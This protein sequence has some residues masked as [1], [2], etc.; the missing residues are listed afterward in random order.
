[1]ETNEMKAVNALRILSVDMIQKA[2]SG[3]PGV[4]IDAAPM[5]FA[6][7]EKVMHFNPNYA[8]WINRDRFVLSA[9]HGS[10]LLYSLL[11]FNGFGLTI[12]D[13]KNFRQLGSKTP[14]HPEVGHTAGV[15]ATTGPLSQGIATAVGMALAEKHLA[16]IYNKPGFPVIDHYTYSLIGD[17]DLMEGL[18]EEALNIAGDK[19]LSKLIVLYDSNDVSLDGPLSLSTD[20]DVKAR[21]EAAGWDYRLVVDGNTD[22]DAI[23]AAIRAAQH[24]NRPSLIE[25]KTTIGYGAPKQGTNAVHGAALGEDGVRKLREFFDW[26]QEPFEFDDE[27]TDAFTKAVED[28][29]VIYDQW[30]KMFAKYSATYPSEAAQLTNSQL[31]M[32]AVTNDYQIGDEIATRVASQNIMNQI[33]KTNP[34]FWGGAADLASSNKTLLKDQGVFTPDDPAGNNIFF[35]VREFGMATAINGI[36]L[37]GGSRAFGS[38]FFVFS[39]Y[40]RAAVR[41]AAIMNLPS[42]FIGSHDSIAVGEDGPTHEPIEQLTSF[43][44]MPNLNLIRPADANETL[45]AWKLIAQTTDRPS[46]LVTSR[47]KLPVLAQT[48]DAPIEKG[49][50]IV[51]DAKKAVPDGIILAAGS[52]VALALAAQKLLLEEEIDVRVV[53][54]PVMNLFEEQSAEYKEAIL[55]ASVTKRLAVE[56]GAS[57]SWGRYVGLNGKVMGI[58]AFG[59]SGKGPEVI[60]HFGFTPRKVAETFKEL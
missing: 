28:K 15:D 9:G 36:N 34:Q 31:D 33:T 19:Q 6:L 50:Y 2:N 57:L 46:F 22:I 42:I 16:A 21:V 13:L 60:E 29:R 56:M 58:D 38:T 1:M 59:A 25:I 44:A 32:S 5:A 40:M 52:E 48:V 51:S 7:W 47:Q 10:S 54:M 26:H 20:E 39:D 18:S 35:G 53:S 23:T 8:N 11:Y 49:A 3:H 37:H 17:G 4:A 55:P 30:A 45:A 24:T 43:R 27:V 12:K 41:L 14:G